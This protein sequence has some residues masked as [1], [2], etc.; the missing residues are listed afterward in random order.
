VAAAV[1]AV[2]QVLEQMAP[3][4]P[5]AAVVLEVL[6]GAEHINK[7]ATVALVL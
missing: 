5:A 4:I 6:V 7:V 2:H 1:R 3:Q